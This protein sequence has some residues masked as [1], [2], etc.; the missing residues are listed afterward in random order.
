MKLPER[1]SMADK[2]PLIFP[3]F[4]DPV[5][6]TAFRKDA[7][8]LSTVMLKAV[9]EYLES[10]KPDEHPSAHSVGAACFLTSHLLALQMDEPRK[11]QVA[12]GLVA[13]LLLNDE[14]SLLGLAQNPPMN[15]RPL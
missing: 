5:A 8:K 9:H 11:S 7:V 3:T 1:Y 12:K 14:S 10:L 6:D 13:T 15:T 2:I 4:T